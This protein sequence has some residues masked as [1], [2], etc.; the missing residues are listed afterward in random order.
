VEN[1]K[2][3]HW[4]HGNRQNFSIE[5]TVFEGLSSGGTWLLAAANILCLVSGSD[6][7]AHTPDYT[8]AAYRKAAYRQ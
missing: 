5:H 6:V 2:P 1:A 4:R 8:P 7:S 3:C